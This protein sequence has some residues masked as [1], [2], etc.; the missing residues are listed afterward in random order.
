M[1]KRSSISC[2]LAM[3][4]MP[5]QAAEEETQ[6]WQQLLVTAPVRDGVTLTME[7]QNRLFDDAS[8]YGQLLL[9][10]SIGFRVFDK[11]TFSVGYAYVNTDI[12]GRPVTHEH[13]AWQ[14]LAFPIMAAGPIQITGRTRLEERTFEHADDVGWRLRQQIRFTMPLD[15][16]GIKAVAW[17]EGFFAFNDTDWGAISGFDRMRNFVGLNIPLA[18]KM[19]L[20]PGYLNQYV[21]RSGEDKIDHTLSVTLSV[22]Y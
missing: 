22:S 10:P 11:T 6:A 16:S 9:R 12:E 18:E 5:A 13:R 19:T 8:D 14:Q 17:T 20:E 1:L 21:N 15:N 2:L 3:L 4:A 7:V